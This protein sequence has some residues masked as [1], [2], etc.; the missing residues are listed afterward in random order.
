MVLTHLRANPGREFT[1]T[2]IAKALDRSAGAI[3][4]ACQNLLADVTIV[5]MSDHPRRYQVSG[6]R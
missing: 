6:A 5:Q 4:N 3:S 2:G 1:A